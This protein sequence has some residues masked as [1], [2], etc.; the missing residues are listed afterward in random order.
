LKNLKELI[1]QKF[2]DA[3][4]INEGFPKEVGKK[5]V[6]AIKERKRL[7]EDFSWLEKSLR[8]TKQ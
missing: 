6:R 4:I 2:V 5:A 7:I 8:E 1:D 3:V